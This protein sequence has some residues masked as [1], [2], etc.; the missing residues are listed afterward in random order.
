MMSKCAPEYLPGYFGVRINNQQ[1]EM[2]PVQHELT[3]HHLV[4]TYKVNAKPAPIKT[5]GVSSTYMLGLNGHATLNV[6]FNLS[7]KPRH[8]TMSSRRTSINVE[9]E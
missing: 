3:Q 8:Y 6:A 9:F 7:E 2:E 4:V 1:A 5:V